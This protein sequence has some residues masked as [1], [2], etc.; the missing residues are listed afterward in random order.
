MATAAPQFPCPSPF[1]GNILKR[2][3]STLTVLK[4][5]NKLKNKWNNMSF[6]CGPLKALRKWN[7]SCLLSLN[8]LSLQGFPPPPPPPP[9]N[10][11]RSFSSVLLLR[12]RNGPVGPFVFICR[13]PPVWFGAK[14]K[15]LNWSGKPGAS[16]FLCALICHSL[17]G[18]SS[19]CLHVF[20]SNAESCSQSNST[21]NVCVSL[22]VCVYL[23]V[24]V[25][26][27]LEVTN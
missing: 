27:P 26:V 13:L 15:K 23:C 4:K 19:S 7:L 5:R 9:V 8:G 3:T 25:A 21:K 10:H 6:V 22:C 18:S 2:G 11:R 20:S 12:L 1:V 16:Y 24:C 17:C 14:T